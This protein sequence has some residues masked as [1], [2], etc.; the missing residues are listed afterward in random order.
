MRWESHQRHA[1]WDRTGQGLPAAVLGTVP[2]TNTHAALCCLTPPASRIVRRGES[3]PGPCSL[4][5]SIKDQLLPPS[6]GYLPP[7]PYSLGTRARRAPP[8]WFSLCTDGALALYAVDIQRPTRRPQ[9]AP[10]PAKPSQ[11]SP[12]RTGSGV[13]GA[14]LQCIE[15]KTA[16]STMPPQ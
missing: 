7:Y 4:G 5:I 2:T 11:E 13:T 3:C 6:L 8:Q 15:D 1:V 14:S 10:F 16:P 12:R 9:S